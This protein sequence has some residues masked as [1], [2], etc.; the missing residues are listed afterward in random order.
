M[1]KSIMNTIVI[2][3]R[4]KAGPDESRC[5]N[6]LHSH[7]KRQAHSDESAEDFHG[8]CSKYRAFSA[9]IK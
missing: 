4:P 5:R 8:I 6:R 3:G 1:G 7:N 2:A 9:V